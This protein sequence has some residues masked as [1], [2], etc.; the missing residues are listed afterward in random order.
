M[1]RQDVKETGQTEQDEWSMHQAKLPDALHFDHQGLE[2]MPEEGT[3]G[4]ERK[5]RRHRAEP[6]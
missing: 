5:V 4:D 2:N 3:R 6:A 1:E